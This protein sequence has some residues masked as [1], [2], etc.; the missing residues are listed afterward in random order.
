MNKHLLLLFLSLSSLT[1]FAQFGPPGGGRPSGDGNGR[2]RSESNE[3]KAFEIT[4]PKGNSKISGIV[5]DSAL[6]KAVEY[7]TI[8]LFDK[9]TNKPIDGTIADDKGRF[10]LTKVAEG[11]YKLVFRFIG[12]ADKT[13]DNVKIGK[14]DNIDVGVIKLNTSTTY[15]RCRNRN[16]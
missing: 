8:A 9:T 1:T 15:P 7:A 14:S 6:T 4:T 11:N 3:P 10:S 5:V 16:G 2:P 12:Y 13:I